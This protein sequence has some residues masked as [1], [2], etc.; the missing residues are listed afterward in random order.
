MLLACSFI[1]VIL[2]IENTVSLLTRCQRGEVIVESSPKKMD[3]S[4]SEVAKQ[5][6]RE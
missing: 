1:R 2:D 3:W 6:Q 5:S 4:E